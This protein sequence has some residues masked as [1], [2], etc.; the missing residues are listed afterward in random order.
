[1]PNR[2]PVLVLINAAGNLFPADTAG[3]ERVQDLT[4]GQ[5]RFLAG[6]EDLDPVAG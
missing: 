1:M 4:T 2:L 5:V 3:K 6:K